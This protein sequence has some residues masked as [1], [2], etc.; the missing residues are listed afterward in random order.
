MIFVTGVSAGWFISMLKERKFF[1][2]DSDNKNIYF[3]NKSFKDE[4]GYLF[5]NILEAEWTC[6]Y[7][8]INHGNISVTED[9]AIVI[10]NDRTWYFY[11]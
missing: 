7:C 3:Y 8:A 11:K 1:H 5:I 6:P 9:F 10:F 2:V 4:P